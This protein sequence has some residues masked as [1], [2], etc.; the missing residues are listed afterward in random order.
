MD[1]SFFTGALSGCLYFPE[2]PFP[3]YNS[4]RMIVSVSVKRW[5]PDER[6][7]APSVVNNPLLHTFPHHLPYQ[8]IYI[9]S[10]CPVPLHTD[11]RPNDVSPPEKH[12][13]KATGQNLRLSTSPASS[14][15][16]PCT[17]MEQAGNSA[18]LQ[19]HAYACTM[20]TPVHMCRR[21]S[22]ALFRLPPHRLRR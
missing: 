14:A 16:L 7:S 8:Q 6:P 15:S 21:T 1:F 4:P 20:T 13:A 19:T 11:L 2:A 18:I 12:H 5:A 9:I 3:I 10:S 17:E 22:T